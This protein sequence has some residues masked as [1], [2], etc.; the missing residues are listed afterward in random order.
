[1]NDKTFKSY[2]VFLIIL[3]ICGFSSGCGNNDFLSVND[4]DIAIATDEP[5]QKEREIN[6]IGI[7]VDATPS[8]EG[9]LGWHSK[10]LN[11][12]YPMATEQQEKEY[13]NLVPLTIY[14]LTLTKINNIISSSFN[15]KDVRYYSIDTTLWRAD[16]NILAEAQDYKFYRDSYYKS[17][18]EMV[19]EY[20][21]YYSLE[22][23]GPS[24]SYAI[25]NASKEDLAV[26]ITDLYENKTNS[27]QVIN[28]LK[29]SVSQQGED[30][31]AA[32]IGVKSQY[33]GRVYDIEGIP[34]KDY[35]VIAETEEVTEQSVKFRPFYIILIGSKERIG[36]FIEQ[37]ENNMDIENVQMEYVIFGD[38]KVYGLDYEDYEAYK[39]SKY[40]YISPTDKDVYH[41]GVLTDIELVKIDRS[42]I[43]NDEK[44][45]L[46]YRI[47]TGTLGE[48]LEM[49]VRS[50]SQ[51]IKINEEEQENGKLI[52]N[53][54][55]EPI[56]F[57]PFGEES[58]DGENIQGAME[59]D[60]IYWLQ[61][62]NQ[63]L[64]ECGINKDKISSG[65]YKFAG[66]VYC[67]EQSLEDEWITDWNSTS[68]NFEG[69]KTQNL[70]SFYNVMRNSFQIED[71]KIVDFLFYLEI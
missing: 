22:Y 32:L 15:A 29:R 45:Y 10:S 37:Y 58:F 63:I 31:G 4:T 13:K 6:T 51:I 62:K 11:K 39:F 18:Y 44:L 28:S 21:D 16:H 5:T 2:S 47:S 70:S 61:S 3:I 33:A 64:L 68:L 1:M 30:M 8:I 26:I 69:E 71:K 17:G 54:Y 14:N 35:G 9:Y 55:V 25:E 7:Y 38:S 23:A 50:D 24:I 27:N 57:L 42:K 67:E 12:K 66:T 41:K 20:K 40:Q 48:Y 60:N 59:I 53:W 49:K 34:D 46:Y 19:D 65:I 56:C 43:G 52:S 36:V